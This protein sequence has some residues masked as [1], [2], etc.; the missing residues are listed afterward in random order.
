[1]TTSFPVDSVAD[2]LNAIK[3]VATG[4]AES[5]LVLLKDIVGDDILLRLEEIDVTTLSTDKITTDK[6]TTDKITSRRIVVTTNR[7]RADHNRLIARECNGLI[8]E[9]PTWRVL[10]YPAQTFNP[11]FSMAEVANNLDS[12]EVYEIQDGTLITLYYYNNAWQMAST[13]GYDVSNYKWFGELTYKESLNQVLTNYPEFSFDKLPHN[14]SLNMGFRH[15]STHPFKYDPQAVWI[16]SAWDNITQKLVNSSFGLPMQNPTA[17]LTDMRKIKAKLDDGMRAFTQSIGR[18]KTTAPPSIFYGYVLRR[19][20]A[21][22][23]QQNKNN[24]VILESDLLKSIRQMMYN[25]P[26]NIPDV[27]TIDINNRLEY[28]CLQAYMNHRT[29]YVF[30]TLFPQ[31]ESYH[32]R[33]N[34]FFTKIADWV[35]GTMK[36]QLCSA[37]DPRHRK[38]V[39]SICAHI[40]EHGNV[41]VSNSDGRGIV[42][43]FLI[44]P[45]YTNMYFACL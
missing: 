11:K 24:N 12:Y 23:N 1:M 29:R 6:I 25:V 4:H 20:S 41:N 5:D 26:K 43:E 40:K 37:T 10:N 14:I 32:K 19:S 16:I 27:L 22:G 18:N 36:G 34:E 17:K 13:N 31:L 44:N 33:Y 9:Y 28:M 45:T 35:I 38:I 21:T 15:H 8:L 42:M 39:V 30:P 3:S 7:L 2:M